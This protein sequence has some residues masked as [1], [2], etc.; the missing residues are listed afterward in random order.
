M[1]EL[2]TIETQGT[3]IYTCAV[4]RAEIYAGLRSG[5]EVATE[6]FFDA[7]GDLPIDA[8]A[9]RRAGVYLSRYAKSHGLEIA[10]ALIAAV[11]RTAGLR[12]WTLNRR[13]YPM[14][15][16]MFYERTPPPPP[17]RGARDARA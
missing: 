15:D 3:A 13:D 11:A 9:G 6:A 17:G 12:L 10:D 4:S 5:E 8:P 2:A 7:R 14:E 16:L 1:G